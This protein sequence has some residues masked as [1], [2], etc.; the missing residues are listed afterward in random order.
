[1]G[2]D[3]GNQ[4]LED[5]NGV[6][7]AEFVRLDCP[8]VV[9]RCGQRWVKVVGKGDRDVDFKD[10]GF[11]SAELQSTGAD[12]PDGYGRGCHAAF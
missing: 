1:M 8:C 7:V 12:K 2:D 9:G 5:G 10:A 4:K 3:L 6:A 11:V